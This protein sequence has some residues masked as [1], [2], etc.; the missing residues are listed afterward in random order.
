M[1]GPNFLCIGQQ[2]AAS[3]WLF[4][5]LRAHDAFWLPPLKELHFFDRGFNFD[6][7]RVRAEELIQRAASAMATDPRDVQFYANA[8]TAPESAS[9]ELRAREYVS[10]RREAR[11]QRQDAVAEMSFNPSP[12]EMDWYRRLFEPAGNRF[13]G[14]ITPAYSALHPAAIRAI[15]DAFPSLDI[16]LL[17]RHPVERLWSLLRRWSPARLRTRLE[18]KSDADPDVSDIERFVLSDPEMLLRSFPSTIWRNW[19]DVFGEER[20]GVFLF[21]DIVKSPERVREDVLQ[22]LGADA[23][24]SFH[25]SAAHN[26][27]VSRTSR[28]KAPPQLLAHLNDFFDAELET[29]RRLF[30]APWE[31]LT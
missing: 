29:C 3:R 7:A 11:H 28:R 4:D 17:I 12:G 13:T 16:I 2:K 1:P 14:E 26:A 19:T 27:K 31:R 10:A 22:F 20:V 18:Q 21:D 15:R 24:G 30:G 23:A 8:L 5:Q 9:I 6:L 25:I